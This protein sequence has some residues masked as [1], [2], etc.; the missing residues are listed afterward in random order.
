MMRL[1]IMAVALLFPAVATAQDTGGR[2]Y[3][4]EFAPGVG[5]GM[6]IGA[7]GKIVVF[8]SLSILR[9]DSQP[10]NPYPA[11]TQ[12]AKVAVDPVSRI[13]MAAAHSSAAANNF[14]QAAQ[15]IESGTAKTTA[16]V[17]QGLIDRGKLLGIPKTYAGLPAAIDKALE[18][19]IGTDV[20]PVTTADAVALRAIAWALWEAGH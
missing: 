17:A 9:S 19:L 2:A 7:D 3:W 15:Q 1:F 11:P 13:S 6:A 12:S 20:R 8:T 5:I 14:A 4:A 18:Q 16:D 10:T